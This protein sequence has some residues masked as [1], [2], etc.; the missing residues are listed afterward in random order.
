MMA[1]TELE[2]RALI[3][4]VVQSCPFEKLA[5]V[6]G[7]IE[8]DYGAMGQR[9]LA[10]EDRYYLLTVLCGRVDAVHPWLYAR[11]R[12]VEAD[13]DGHLDLWAREHYK[14]TMI[15]FAGAIQEILRAAIACGGSSISD[16]V[17]ALGEKGWFQVQHRAYGREGEPCTICGAPIKKI[18]VAQR[19]THFCAQCQKR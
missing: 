1:P 5:E 17:D 16:Y 15:T 7:L 19:G 14:S 8:A 2:L 6:W 10:R 12:E 11:C 3:R 13:P 4:P 18:L 9:A